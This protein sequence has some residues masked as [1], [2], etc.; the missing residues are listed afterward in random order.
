MQISEFGWVSFP[1]V[2]SKLS[3]ALVTN[4]SSDLEGYVYKKINNGLPWFE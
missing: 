3:H 2:L 1:P 4:W